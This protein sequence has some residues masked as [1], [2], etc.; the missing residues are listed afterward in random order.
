MLSD[1]DIFYS[2]MAGTIANLNFSEMSKDECLQLASCC[3]EAGAGLCHCLGAMGD[4]MVTLASHDP[5]EFTSS[6]I[7]QIGHSLAAISML[8]PMLFDLQQLIQAE[9]GKTEMTES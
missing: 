2:R 1:A 3:E 9:L 8:L 6:N 5:R 7:F 4:F